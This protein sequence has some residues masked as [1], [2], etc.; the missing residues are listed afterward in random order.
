MSLQSEPKP[1]QAELALSPLARPPSTSGAEDSAAESGEKP[2][3][4][5]EPFAP[6]LKSAERG[7]GASR[8]SWLAFLGLFG[9]LLIGVVEYATGPEISFTLFYV[10]PVAMATWFGGRRL[11]LVA[12]FASALASFTARAPHDAQLSHLFTPSWNA[13]TRLL[14]FSLGVLLLALLRR[15]RDRLQRTVERKSAGLELAMAERALAE[16]EVL[17]AGA[18]EQK[19]IAYDLHDDLGQQLVGIAFKAK[20]LGDKLQSTQ[21]AEADEAANIARLA[22]DAARQTRLTAHKLDDTASALDLRTALPRLAVAIQENCR[23]KVSVNTSAYSAPV[24]APVAAQLYRIAQEAVRNA[25]EHGR[26]KTV[27]IYLVSHQQHVVLT[28]RDD[29]C[30]FK[31][32]VAEQGMGF[33]IMG[34]RAESV[35]GSCEVQSR[36]GGVTLICRVPIDGRPAPDS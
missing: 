32:S 3:F 2:M 18:R 36:R 24:D 26:A 4:Q 31:S 17:D 10:P 20:L 16:R 21:P 12:G 6:V 35:G 5:S 8:M 22:N 30:G 7:A 28:V 9:V 27:E 33:R 11:G 13:A 1:H 29:G 15:Q 19:R 25:V 23:V 34:S 14:V